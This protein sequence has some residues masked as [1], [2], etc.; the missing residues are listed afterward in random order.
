LTGFAGFTE[1][2]FAVGTIT[3]TH[4][5]RGEVR[6]FPKTDFEEQRF[7]S[8]SRLYIRNSDISSYRIV[9]IES[10]HKHKNMWIVSFANITSVSDAEKLKGMDLC[11]PESDLAALPKDTYFIHQLVGLKVETDS[12]TFVGNL[13]EV[14]TPGANDVY[15]VRGPLQKKDLLLP[16]IPACVQS[17]DIEAGV[18]TIHMMPGLLDEDQ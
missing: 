9:T 16:A 1:E 7:R 18:M 4:G 5:I 14:L 15:V 6:V 12:G 11:I 10:A 3:S 17:V 13:V 8:G 2:Y